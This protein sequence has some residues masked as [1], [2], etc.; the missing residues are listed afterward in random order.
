MSPFPERTVV[1]R[2]P[3]ADFARHGFVLLLALFGLTFPVA[4]GG[5]LSPAPAEHS[6][7]DFGAGSLNGT[8]VFSTTGLNSST[9][10]LFVTMVGS[11]T[12]NGSGGITG[13]TVDLIGV[14]AGV[15]S[16]AAQPITDGSYSVGADGRGQIHFDTTTRAGPVTITLDFVL[17]SSAHGLVTEYDGNG[18]GSGTLDLQSAITQSQLAGSYVFSLSGTAANGTS[19]TWTIGAFTL[20]STGAV[21]TGQEDVNQAGSYSGAPSQ[22]LTKSAVILGTT[23]AT[24]TIASS[25]GTSY[26]FDVYPI[27]SGHLKFIEND[28]Q[29]LVSG[30][31]YTQGISIPTGQ[32]VFRCWPI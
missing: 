30:D 6:I 13:G 32:L 29:L 23:P 20:N 14:N 17:I 1:G 31:A 28:S 3:S 26:T 2:S 11:L 7:S 5:G 15:S 18:I 9:A 22:I 25:A 16:P 19:P 27:D 21:L 4:C 10:P 12:A 8:Y 24:A